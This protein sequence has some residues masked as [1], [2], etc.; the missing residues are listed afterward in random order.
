MCSFDRAKQPTTHRKTAM[1]VCNN[2]DDSRNSAFSSS[3]T[4][5]RA[6]SLFSSFLIS[7]ASV[8]AGAVGISGG[9][10]TAAFLSR[11]SSSSFC[12]YATSVSPRRKLRK[13]TTHLKLPL[14]FS[15]SA[16]LASRS[17]SAFFHLPASRSISRRWSANLQRSSSL[18]R[19]VSIANEP[20]VESERTRSPESL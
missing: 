5:T 10:T 18:R 3:N 11:T 8:G 2:Y 1:R 12:L 14:S 9:G 20:A 7:S 13:E 4:S 6:R 19:I 16:S 17:S 15:K